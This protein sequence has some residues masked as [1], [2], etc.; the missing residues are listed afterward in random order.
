M[1]VPGFVPLV[2]VET[3]QPGSGSQRADRWGAGR[4]P[5][6]PSGLAKT[7]SRRSLSLPQASLRV[8]GPVPAC[9]L[10]ISAHPGEHPL[11]GE[12]GPGQGPQC[13]SVFTIYCIS[14]WPSFHICQSTCPTTDSC[15]AVV[16]IIILLVVFI[17]R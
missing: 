10:T 2:G 12:E 13:S 14:M 6:W 11:L 9:G 1:G 17:L 16:V 8:L 15:C 7:G 5:A 4:G 3:W